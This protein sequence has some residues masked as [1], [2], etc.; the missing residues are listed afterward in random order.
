MPIQEKVVWK[1]SSHGAHSKHGR[2]LIASEALLGQIPSAGRG[3]ARVTIDLSHDQGIPHHAAQFDTGIFLVTLA[4]I[5]LAAVSLN[6]L[7]KRRKK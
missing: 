1:R 2:D 5:L 3:S 4:I 7:R 6:Y